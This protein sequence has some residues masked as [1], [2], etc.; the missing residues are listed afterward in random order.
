MT[1]IIGIDGGGTKTTCLFLKADERAYPKRPLMVKGPGTN[2]HVVGFEEAGRRLESLIRHGMKTFSLAP[3]EISGAGMGLAG[4][5]RRDEIE[6]MV[7]TMR[8]IFFN[9]YFSENL[10]LYI[11]SDVHAA[12][13]GSLA[14][15]IEEGMLLISGTGSNAVGITAEGKIVTC[16]G[17][18]HLIGDEGSGYH[19]SLKA[20][21][22]VAKAADGRGEPTQMTSYIL[23][24]CGLERPEQLIRCLYDRP[25]EKKEV[26]ALAPYIIEASE[27]GDKAAVDLLKEA[28][29]E[30]VL[31][32]ESLVKQGVDP[33]AP[34]SAAGSILTYSQVLRNHVGKLLEDRQF[35]PLTDPY[36]PPEYGAALLGRSAGMEKER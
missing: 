29:E 22:K 23:R 35:G 13:K 16:G 3:Q 26:A 7:G 27:Q 1:Y 8:T 6:Q 20:L 24:A 10:N 21:S 18:G 4:V 11:T 17:W 25:F 12:L 15:G 2:P 14:P 31:H 30:L 36:A 33:K 19:L 34:V 5:G 28:A 32:I 9:P